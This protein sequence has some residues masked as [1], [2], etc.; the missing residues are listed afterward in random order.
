MVEIYFKLFLVFIY[1]LQVMAFTKKQ[2]SHINLK[3]SMSS[4]QNDYD[5]NVM[6]TYGRYPLTISHGKGIRLYD[7]EGINT[8]HI[9]TDFLP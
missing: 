8:V 3:I 2:L 9:V 4:F 7:L 6:N 5:N 1:T